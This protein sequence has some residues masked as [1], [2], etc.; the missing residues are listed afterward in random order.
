MLEAKPL[1][2]ADIQDVRAL[3]DETIARWPDSSNPET[4]LVRLGLY[5]ISWTINGLDQNL[6]ERMSWVLSEIGFKTELIQ[7]E[8]QPTGEFVVQTFYSCCAKR[9]GIFHPDYLFGEALAVTTLAKMYSGHLED[10]QLSGTPR[11][12]GRIF[13]GPEA[14]NI[15]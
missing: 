8:V 2:D 11:S 15:S 5:E 7:R 14:G 4:A 12:A 10:F 3:I 1:S 6:L 13:Y 9:E